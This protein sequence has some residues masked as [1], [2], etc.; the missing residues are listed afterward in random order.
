MLKA[1]ISIVQ[2]AS[3]GLWMKKLEIPP[4][5]LDTG[6]AGRIKAN[7]KLNAFCFLLFL[8][9]GGADRA[10]ARGGASQSGAQPRVTDRKKIKPWKG[11]RSYK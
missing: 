2:D 1:R 7:E 9:A 10:I 3:P 8:R 6:S 11:G 4:M 5:E